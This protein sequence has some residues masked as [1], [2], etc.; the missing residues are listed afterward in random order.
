MFATPQI[1]TSDEQPTA[2]IHLCVP[3]AEIGQVMAPA[4]EEIL[5]ALAAA[6]T[7]P[8]GPCYS[9]H[10]QRPTDTFDFEVGFPVAAPIAP[11]GRVKMSRLPAT[12]LARTTYS[13]GYEGL[14]AAWGEFCAWIDQAGLKAT[15]SLWECY[16]VGHN[17]SPDPAE[18]RTELNR[19]LAE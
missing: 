16:L 10:W 14:G 5:A 6:G 13:G 8:C 4:I 3:R 17:T 15:G 19:P 9:F 7:A 12:R 1:L 11:V 18:W 2:V